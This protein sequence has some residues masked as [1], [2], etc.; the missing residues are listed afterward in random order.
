MLES[1]SLVVFPVLE[2]AGSGFKPRLTLTL[3]SVNTCYWLCTIITLTARSLS[4]PYRLPASPRVA[5]NSDIYPN[6]LFYSLLWDR[7]T[8]SQ[9][10]RL[11]YVGGVEIF[12]YIQTVLGCTQPPIK[13]VPGVKTAKRRNIGNSN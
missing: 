5:C 7:Y 6:F 1:P 11:S 12:L 10:A 2:G 8:V 4:I 9:T 13:R 3:A